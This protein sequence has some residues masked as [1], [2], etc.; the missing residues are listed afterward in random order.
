MRFQ[1]GRDSLIIKQVSSFGFMTCC[2]IATLFDMHI[3]ICQRRLR[4]LCQGGYLVRR[5]LPSG[6][7]GASPYIYSLGRNA[8]YLL[9]SKASDPRVTLRTPHMLRNNDILISIKKTC[10][11]AGLVCRLMPEHMIRQ[12][13]D[14]LYPDGAFIVK[15]ALFLLE[16]D[17]GLETLKSLKGH[18]DITQKFLSYLAMFESNSTQQYSEFFS[19]EFLRFRLLILVPDMK[20]LNAFLD[21]IRNLPHN[22]FIFLAILPE[23]EE[24][25]IT[26]NIWHSVEAGRI[27]IV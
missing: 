16:H 17:S 11:K 1:E 5:A 23:F 22:H 20:R 14:S 9:K 4:K 26:G 24:A 13:P 6:S 27:K 12:S 7:L 3:K 21:I 8:E 2:Q 19:C 10:D 18:S 25:G 15:K